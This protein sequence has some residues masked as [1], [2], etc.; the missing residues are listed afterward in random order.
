MISGKLENIEGIIMFHPVTSHTVCFGLYLSYLILSMAF[1]VWF[2]S[3]LQYITFAIPITI[4]I[5]IA[6]GIAK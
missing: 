2:K 1:E 4:G 6:N 3:G 5:G